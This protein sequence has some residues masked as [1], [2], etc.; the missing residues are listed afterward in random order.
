MPIKN[1]PCI[2]NEKGKYYAAHKENH[3]NEEI[4]KMNEQEY[5]K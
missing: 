3:G 1:E 5:Y 4:N 2:N